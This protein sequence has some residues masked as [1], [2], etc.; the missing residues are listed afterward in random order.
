[1]TNPI[2]LHQP[3]QTNTPV[4]E[5]LQGV[6]AN[7]YGLYLATHNYHWN[8]EGYNFASLHALFD[9]QY[10]EL[11]LA[12]DGIAEHIRALGDYAL[13]FEGDNLTEVFKMTSNPLNKETDADARAKRMVRNL[14]SL[15][16]AVIKTCQMAK[17]IAQNAHDDESENLLVERI[18][19]HQKAMWM[20]NSIVK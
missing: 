19:A 18:T 9:A 1:M 12:I 3:K 6:L 11:F 7:T 15:N 4:A 13:P 2:T 10:N 16:E 5:A 14:I 20:L 17:D 8:V